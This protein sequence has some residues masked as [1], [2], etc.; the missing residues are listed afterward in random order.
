MFYG[1]A[2]LLLYCFAVC[3]LLLDIRVS[4][5]C[6]DNNKTAAVCDYFVLMDGGA[7]YVPFCSLAVVVE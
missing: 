6:S 5:I 1:E 3:A 4:H 7:I 2:S